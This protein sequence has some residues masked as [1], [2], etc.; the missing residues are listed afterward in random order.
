[1][2][3]EL[4]RDINELLLSRKRLQALERSGILDTPQEAV[5]DEITA[6]IVDDLSVP[7][8]M[9]SIVDMN[10]QFLKSQQGLP[11]PFAKNREI[12]ISHAFCQHTIHRG[13]TYAIGDMRKAPVFYDHPSVVN[14]NVMAYLG[15]PLYF[16]GEIIGTVC[17][18][19]FKP[20]EWT[21]A[22]INNLKKSAKAVLDEITTTVSRGT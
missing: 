20:R 10:R 4:E 16:D 5:Y 3:E 6:Q 13:S 21:E 2:Y 14:F 7:I 22:D 15:E 17:V 1:M 19:D 12:P 8:S 18:I 9:V 11:D